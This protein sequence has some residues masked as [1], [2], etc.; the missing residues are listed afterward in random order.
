[1]FQQYK[2]YNGM[3]E[4]PTVTEIAKKEMIFILSNRLPSLE[5]IWLLICLK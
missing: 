5:T 3:Y 1:M 4:K 2:K